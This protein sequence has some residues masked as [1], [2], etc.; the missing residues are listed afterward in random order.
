[1]TSIKANKN[2][3]ELKSMIDFYNNSQKHIEELL[4]YSSL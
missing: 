2:N 3:C 1:M 4:C